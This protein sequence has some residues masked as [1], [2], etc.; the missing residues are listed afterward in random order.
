MLD[1]RS[2]RLA[3][4]LLLVGELVSLVGL[5]HPGR[6]PANNHPA[7]FAEYAASATWT[8]VHFGQFASTA[9]VMAGLVAFFYALNVQTGWLRWSGLFAVVS[10]VVTLGLTAVLQAVDGVALKQAVD[11]WMRAPDADKTAR[12]ATAEA[13]RWLEWGVRSYQRSM[14]GGSLLLFAALLVRT[15]RVPT[16]IGYLAGLTGLAYLG[17]GVVVGNEG[18]SPNGT[19][20]SL[21]ALVLEPVWIIWRFVS[22][23]RMRAPSPRGTGGALACWRGYRYRSP[24]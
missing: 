15:A 19:A 10:A 13:I 7:V 24:P 9:I 20:V 12:F 4:A 3:A 18:F 11:A 16:P 5:L 17:Q 2:L 8:A 14:L 23:A 1:R 21:L 22:M 6:E